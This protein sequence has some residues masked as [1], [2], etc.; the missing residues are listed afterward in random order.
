[1]AVTAT[2]YGQSFKSL[3][4]GRFDFTT[5]T[6]KLLLT[7]SSYTPTFDLDE[8]RDDVTNEVTGTG[9]TA[10]GATL[11]G[12]SWVYDAANDRCQLS[13]DPVTW[14]SATFTARRGVIYRSTGTAAT[15][16]LLSW[17]DFGANA[18]PSGIDFTLTFPNGIYR[19]KLPA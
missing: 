15:D 19:L 4:L 11:A 9:Y 10:G 6:F 1:M 7:T 16:P 3:G 17:V 18:S 13:C 8:F 14:T 2:P 5:H 12:L